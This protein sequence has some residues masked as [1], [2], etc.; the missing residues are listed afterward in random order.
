MASSGKYRQI[1]AGYPATRELR[2]ADGSLR[3]YRIDAV[4]LPPLLAKAADLA[5]YGTAIGLAVGGYFLNKAMWPDVPLL[6]IVTIG[7]PL[8][9]YAVLG[10]L[11]RRLFHL[12]RTV[13]ILR[14]EILVHRLF[15]TERYDRRVKHGFGRAQHDK[16]D[17]EKERHWWDQ[18]QNAQ[19]G[20]PTKY[21]QESW[22]IVLEYA[23][24]RICL[25]SVLG[26]KPAE[27]IVN[28]LHGCD[29]AMDG[30]LGI[31]GMTF[32]P[33]DAY[34]SETGDIPL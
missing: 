22:H 27:A 18:R 26:Q 5:G 11:Y 3:G 15:G 19:G 28:R 2:A 31:G 20:R 17:D 32:D 12:T 25:L 21:Y 9:S 10:W 1:F 24:Q 7:G 13:E 4:Y 6:L 33:R 23:H 30:K 16:A 34:S 8:A 29:E 14:D